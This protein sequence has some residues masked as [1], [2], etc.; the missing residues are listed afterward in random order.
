MRPLS[1]H[2]Q[3]SDPC[4]AAAAAGHFHTRVS[5]GGT[6]QSPG[7]GVPQSAARAA[8]HRRP[9]AHRSSGAP[10]G[11][12]S[13][14]RPAVSRG[15]QTKRRPVYHPGG[16]IHRGTLQIPGTIP[17][18]QLP[19]APSEFGNQNSK[20]LTPRWWRELQRFFTVLQ[21]F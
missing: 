18:A 3:Q 19:A 15:S 9:A 11:G 4:S 12:G 5:L 1:F 6:C 10:G 13:G 7:G 17:P 14:A 21:K 20:T 8:H 2:R 16:L